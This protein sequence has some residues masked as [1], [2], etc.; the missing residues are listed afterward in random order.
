MLNTL[1]TTNLIGGW[2]TKLI[3]TI[4]KNNGTHYLKCIELKRKKSVK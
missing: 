1:L 2:V 3:Q 4:E